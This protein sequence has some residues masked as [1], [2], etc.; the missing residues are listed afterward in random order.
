M[1]PRISIVTPTFNQ[2]Q[3][4]EQTIQSV[5]NQNYPNLEY[6]IIDGGSIDA[7]LEII[8]QY[9]VQLY[10]MPPEEFNHELTRQFGV[11]KAK[12]EF[13]VFTVLDAM[14]HD[15]YWIKNM[16]RHFMDE[17]VTGVYGQQIVLQHKDKN[18]HQWFRPQSLPKIGIKHFPEKGSFE[19]LDNEAQFRASQWDDVTACYRASII[20]NYPFTRTGFAEDLIWAKE[21]LKRGDKLI[22]DPNAMVEHYHHVGFKDQAKRTLFF[23]YH[24]YSFFN[25]VPKNKY[26][27]RILPYILYRNFKYRASLKCFFYHAK[28]IFG[29]SLAYIIFRFYKKFR[30]KY[31]ASVLE[32]F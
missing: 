19:K 28:L 20:K 15:E 23:L 29:N 6:I 13:I 16:I 10:Q 2:G 26:N 21:A 3:Y 12:G 1:L 14:A 24:V 5:I 25:F 27:F 7:T 8:K 22:S 11:E 31:L 9:P 32:L 30:R 17:K 4:I 18:P